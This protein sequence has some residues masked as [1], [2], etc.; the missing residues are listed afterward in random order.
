MRVEATDNEVC[1]EEEAVFDSL[2]RCSAVAMI[3]GWSSRLRVN[4]HHP[5]AAIASL[6]NSVRAKD[7]SHAELRIII[8]L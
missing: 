3:S 8:I 6:L 1:L 7:F 4:G 5:L 2:L